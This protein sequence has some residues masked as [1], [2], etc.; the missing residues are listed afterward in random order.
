MEYL[1]HCVGVLP[2]VN[3]KGVFYLISTTPPTGTFTLQ[4]TPSFAQHD[5]VKGIVVRG[6]SITQIVL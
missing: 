2:Y 4:G 5:N 6:Q 3:S 1:I